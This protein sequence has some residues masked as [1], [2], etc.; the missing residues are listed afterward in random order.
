MASDNPNSAPPEN[1]IVR[2][3]L[4]R[5]ADGWSERYRLAVVNEESLEEVQSYRLTRLNIYLFVSSVLV[6]TVLFTMF[7]FFV[8]PLKYLIPGYADT[9]ALSTRKELTTLYKRID[10]LEAVTD[11]HRNYTV[12]LGKALRGEKDAA[13]DLEVPAVIAQNAKQPAVVA[14]TTAS[15][16]RF[17]PRSSDG[18]L[19]EE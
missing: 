6:G 10:S 3:A 19:L 2:A 13:A 7:L 14:T 17:Y 4:A 8:T 12:R 11:A 9:N 18:K 16:R 15:Q 1:S 5:L